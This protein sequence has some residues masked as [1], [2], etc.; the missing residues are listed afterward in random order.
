MITSTAASIPTAAVATGTPGVAAPPTSAL[1]TAGTTAIGGS[2][3]PGTYLRIYDG[4]ALLGEAIADAKGQWNLA[5]PSL[6]PGQ[7]AI[8]A[9]VYGADGKLVSSSAPLILTVTPPTGAVTPAPAAAKGAPGAAGT[10]AALQ[11]PQITGLKP[12]AELSAVSPVLL[13]GIAPP[14]STVRSYDGEKLLIEV[15][16]APDGSWRVVLPPLTAGTHTIAARILSPGGSE[17]VSSAPLTLT[18][19]P[20]PTAAPAPAAAGR[21]NVSEPAPG[22]PVQSGQPV[23]SGIAAPNG[24][25]RVYDG[26]VLL[27]E[28]RATAQGRWYLVSPFV[29]AT[30][31][32]GVRAVGVG[33]DGVEVVG[34]SFELTIAAGATGTKPPVFVPPTGKGSSQVGLLQGVAPPGILVSIV[35]GSTLLA[36]VKA[37][38]GGSWQYSLPNWTAAG[39]HTYSITA[40]T[41]D[42]A[43]VYRPEPITVSI[44]PAAQQPVSDP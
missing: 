35:E 28:T 31:K 20:A 12:G 23:F 26:D 17:A 7:H 5:I 29:L 3:T 4:E 22:R 15:A 40:A 34:V 33:A 32:H 42:G 11:P 1:P 14:G 10:P 24:I 16:A 44:E 38:A 13:E 25:V 37:D 36:R 39:Q 19:K 21:P 18:V 41:A 6:A 30:G 9:R 27:G 8:T 2:A 43:V